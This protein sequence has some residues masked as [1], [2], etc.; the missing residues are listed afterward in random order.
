MSTKTTILALV[1]AAIIGSIFYLESQ[2]IGPAQIS[3]KTDAEIIITPE[4]ISK[5]THNS[6]EHSPG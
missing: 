4:E 5:K 3:D 2:K 6:G 1:I